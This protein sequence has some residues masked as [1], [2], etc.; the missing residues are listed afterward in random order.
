VSASTLR[1]RFPPTVALRGLAARK[2]QPHKRR[3]RWWPNPMESSRPRAG[4]AVLVA[5]LTGRHLYLYTRGHVARAR[6]LRA[7]GVVPIGACGGRR[8]KATARRRHRANRLAGVSLLVSSL[9]FGFGCDGIGR[10]RRALADGALRLCAFGDV[11]GCV[12]DP[13]IFSFFTF[14]PKIYGPIFSQLYI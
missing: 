7:L 4:A 6:R 2:A 1:A 10:I 13:R 11:E 14:F 9:P 8:P 3:E 5:S 12:S